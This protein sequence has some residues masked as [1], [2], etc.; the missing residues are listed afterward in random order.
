MELS[1]TTHLR[2]AK[3][4]IVAG[5][6]LVSSVC[7]GCNKEINDSSQHSIRSFGDMIDYYLMPENQE[8]RLVIDPG[9]IV[10]DFSDSKQNPYSGEGGDVNYN[11]SRPDTPVQDPNDNPTPDEEVDANRFAPTTQIFLSSKYYSQYL[12]EK[13]Y[14]PIV[15]ALRELPATDTKQI[16]FRVFHMGYDYDATTRTAKQ[17]AVLSL[18]SLG[19]IRR[20]GGLSMPT[21]IQQWLGQLPENARVEYTS[22]RSYEII[23]S[24]YSQYDDEDWYYLSG[25]ENDV[26]FNADLLKMLGNERL[27]LKTFGDY[28][29]LLADPEGETI[30]VVPNMP[31][32][33]LTSVK[34]STTININDTTSYSTYNKTFPNR[35]VEQVSTSDLSKVFSKF[36]QFITRSC[37]NPIDTVYS[38]DSS[39]L[40]AFVDGYNKTLIYIGTAPGESLADHLGDKASLITSTISGAYTVADWMSLVSTYPDATYIP[41]GT[42]GVD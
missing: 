17:G 41:A 2:R 19:S 1:R 27:G 26:S 18:S 23:A 25:D 21:F 8:N 37:S 29:D 38:D 42:I 3:A 24:N 34:T 33:C 31:Y 6:I 15:E 39:M 11:P 10:V 5:S 14:T 28:R 20:V 7:T 30:G 13:V 12:R 35:Y 4:A 16:Y 22:R 36:N 9:A 40:M 32:K